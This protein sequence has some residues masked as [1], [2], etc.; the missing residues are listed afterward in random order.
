MTSSALTKACAVLIVLCCLLPLAVLGAIL[1][2]DAP[3]WPTSLAALFIV[4]LLA[5]RLFHLLAKPASD[6]PQS[7]DDFFSEEGLLDHDH[8]Q[9]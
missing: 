7:A 9:Y 4:G 2:F 1:F 6:T 8:R 3:I 5:M